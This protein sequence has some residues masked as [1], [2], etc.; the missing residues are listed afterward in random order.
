MQLNDPLQL[1]TQRGAVGMDL[2]MPGMCNFE[3][4]TCIDWIKKRWIRNFLKQKLPY[5]Q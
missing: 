5:D 4:I 1:P 2:L 3:R